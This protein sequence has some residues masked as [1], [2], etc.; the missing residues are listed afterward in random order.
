[1]HCP[2]TLSN[3]ARMRELSSTYCARQL[4]SPLT[5]RICEAEMALRYAAL[6][7]ATV[8]AEKYIRDAS[9]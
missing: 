7:A 9:G 8:R 3:V 1:M 2:D 6:S 5:T 4:T